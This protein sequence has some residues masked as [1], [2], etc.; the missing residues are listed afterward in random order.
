MTDYILSLQDLSFWGDLQVQ[1]DNVEKA[2]IWNYKPS[3]LRFT[4]T[5]LLKRVIH[6]L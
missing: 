4:Q 3:M 5:E 2:E 1:P 6:E